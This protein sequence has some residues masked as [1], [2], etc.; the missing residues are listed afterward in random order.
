MLTPP[1]RLESLLGPLSPMFT[2]LDSYKLCLELTGMLAYSLLKNLKNPTIK[3][4]PILIS[5]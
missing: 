3:H 4:P 2:G 1:L 5:F